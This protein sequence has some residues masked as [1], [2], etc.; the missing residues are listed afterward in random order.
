MK[1]PKVSVIIPSYNHAPFLHRR[2]ESVLDQTYQD[3]EIIYLDDASTD[4]SNEVFSAYAG[5]GRI[6]AFFNEVNTGIPGKQWNKGV[7]EARGE[8]VWIA[9]SDDYADKHFLEMLVT[10][11]EAYPTAG[12]VYCQSWVVNER[13]EIIGSYDHHTEDFDRTR[14]KRN[15]F[16]KGK[17]ELT[18][19]LLYKN[20][21]PNASA[22]LFRKRIYEEARYADEWVRYCGDW[23]L[24]VKMLM[25]SD[26]VFVARP[27]NYHR[28]HTG[29]LSQNPGN[30][31]ALSPMA[32]DDVELP[33]IPFEHELRRWPARMRY[34]LGRNALRANRPEEA[35]HYFKQSLRLHVFPSTLLF[36]IVSF[37]GRPAYHR[38]DGIKSRIPI[39]GRFTRKLNRLWLSGHRFLAKRHK[40]S[41]SG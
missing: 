9:E 20:T 10:Q 26:L 16:N 2:I 13:D 4:H 22:V 12:L 39:F 40:R 6:R 8:Y 36:W 25:I 30:N 21:I 31:V 28:R 7:R 24:W 15:F 19:Y 14:W 38:L 11:L 33:D 37:L 29:S 18:N 3:F 35:R 1:V 41:Q 34:I 32:H 5:D 27:L 23:L 17:D